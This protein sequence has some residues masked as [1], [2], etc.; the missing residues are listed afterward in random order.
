M[1]LDYQKALE[2][3]YEAEVCVVGGGPAGVAAAVM[4]AEAGAKVLIIEQSGS[5]GGA[6]TLGMVPEIM[7]FDDGEHFLAGGFG[8]RLH[9]A[10]FPPCKYEREWMIA[11]PED[12]KR[13]YDR[14]ICEAGVEFLFFNKLNPLSLK[15]SGEEKR[16]TWLL[17]FKVIAAVLPSAVLGVFLDD[18]L[19]EHL[20]NYVV[21][22]IMLIV[23]GVAFLLVEW[24]NRKQRVVSAVTDTDG[25]TFRHAI[26][27][28]AFQC[29]ALIPGTSRSGA[30]ILGAMLLGLS[31]TAASEFSFFLAIPTMVG[32]SLL[33]GYKFVD[34]VAE[35]GADV[36][37]TAILCLAVGFVTAFLVSL[38][39]IKFLMDF[40]RKH[41]FSSFAIYRITLGVL[42]LLFFLVR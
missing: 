25:I 41:S 27:I 3:R 17:W 20:Y 26:L 11:S 16:G 13:L 42:V 36:S 4:A 18:L 24:K 33:R 22:A 7:N 15:K 31:R 34:Y 23:Y 6:G 14:M 35:S 9:D 32:A 10:L 1:K 39:A 12:T 5:F 2:V 37:A 38:A 21:V 30:T 40:V 28:G 8:R 29:L 19:D